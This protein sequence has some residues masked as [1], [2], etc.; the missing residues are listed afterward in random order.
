[1]KTL[2]AFLVM[3]AAL[4][5]TKGA[6]AAQVFEGKIVKI[7][8]S[9]VIVEVISQFV[10][11]R[12][13]R[14]EIGMGVPELDYFDTKALGVV[15]QT[16]DNRI[17][18][19]VFTTLAKI[20]EFHVARI[21]SE[22][23]VARVNRQPN[24]RGVGTNTNQPNSPG[25][26]ITPRIRTVNFDKLKV[27]DLAVDALA[28]YGIA[29][30]RG[31]GQ[32]LVYEAARSQV[33]P[34]GRRHLLSA[35]TTST[36]TSRL[37]FTFTH[38]LMRFEVVRIGVTGGGSLPKWELKA[39]DADGKV[40]AATGENEWGFDQ[41]AKRF[42]VTASNIVAVQI[43]ADNRFGDGTFATYSAL[44]IAELL[45]EA[46]RPPNAS[47]GPG[48]DTPPPSPSDGFIGPPRARSSGDP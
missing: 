3:A 15:Q 46:D 5:A 22:A 42:S 17:V 24:P 48:N 23:P 44:P 2:C 21:T 40:I 10:P 9:E 25:L 16:I 1:M 8:G 29:E 13:D 39:L 14:V 31:E 27:D 33:L 37:S 38:P 41:Q 11:N 26:D 34:S 19:D 35:G 47:L 43:D 18:V 45:M 36:R 6:P 7:D 28:K 4:F 20:E 12:G 32:P 30:L